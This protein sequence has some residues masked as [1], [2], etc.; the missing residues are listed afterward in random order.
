MKIIQSMKNMQPQ[1]HGITAGT[2]CRCRS[3]CKPRLGMG[4]NERVN[5]RE[6]PARGSPLPR[7]MG[8]LPAELTQDQAL[9][10]HDV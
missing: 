10:F 7:S 1:Q 9:F 6:A 5:A 4:S 8:A 3:D 2:L